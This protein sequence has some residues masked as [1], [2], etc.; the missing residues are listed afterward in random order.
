MSRMVARDPIPLSSALRELIALRGFA[1]ARGDEELVSAWAT[2]AGPELAA[3][4]RPQQVSRGALTISVDS[5]AL[6]SELT[7]FQG[8][9]LTLRMKQQFPHLKIRNLKFKLSGT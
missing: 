7:G 9:E 6:L 5:P 3:Q 8:P 2:V 1:R 4:T